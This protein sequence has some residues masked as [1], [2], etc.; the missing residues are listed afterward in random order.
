VISGEWYQEALLA[1]ASFVPTVF[2]L[3]KE[4]RKKKSISDC[5]HSSQQFA[6]DTS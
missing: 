4:N 2:D 3:T 5:S 1:S 6:V